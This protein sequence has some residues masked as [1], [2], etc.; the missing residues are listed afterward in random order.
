MTP[1]YESDPEQ[2]KVVPKDQWYAAPARRDG[3]ES[4]RGQAAESEEIRERTA[5]GVAELKNR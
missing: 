2:P 4:R 1:E 5:R 3:I